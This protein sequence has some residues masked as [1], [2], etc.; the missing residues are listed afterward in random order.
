MRDVYYQKIGEIKEVYQQMTY[1]IK[2]QLVKYEIEVSSFI[3]TFKNQF[4]R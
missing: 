4:E 1:F 3:K 2:E